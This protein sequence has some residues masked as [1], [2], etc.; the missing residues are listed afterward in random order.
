MSAEQLLDRLTLD[1]DQILTGDDINEDY[2]HDECVNVDPVMP[3]VVLTP[4]SAAKSQLGKAERLRVRREGGT[5]GRSAGAT[6]GSASTAGGL[7]GDAA[8]DADDYGHP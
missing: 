4:R 5:T 1:A 2:S 6:S 3:A 7:P 8:R